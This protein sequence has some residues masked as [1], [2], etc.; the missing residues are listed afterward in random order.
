MIPIGEC[1]KKEK[2]EES[3]YSVESLWNLNYSWLKGVWLL[4]EKR[5]T[6]I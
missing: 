6:R 2:A 5:I 3:F 1:I 4:P